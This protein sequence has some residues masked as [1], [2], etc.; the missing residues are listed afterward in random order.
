ME[1]SPRA[2]RN[3]GE[4]KRLSIY[5]IAASILAAACI[6]ALIFTVWFTAVIIDDRGMEPTLERGDAVLCDKLALTF[7]S[8]KRGDMLCYRAVYGG[9]VY[10]GRVVG[11]AGEEVAINGGSVYINGK[12]LEESAYWKYRG[13]IDLD[14]GEVVVPENSAF[15]VGD[16]RNNSKDSRAWGVGAIPYERITGRA[17][18]VIWPLYA[19]RSI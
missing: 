18:F 14:M 5:T 19:A 11:L 1:L 13:E 17:H 3:R 2:A 9:G 6:V 16:N 15:V 8:P 12:E 7:V 10:M 4:Y